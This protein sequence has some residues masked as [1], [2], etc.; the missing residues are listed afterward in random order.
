MSLH[1]ISP[2]LTARRV[3]A[4]SV[5]RNPH[6]GPVG[7]MR[8]GL[9]IKGADGDH[10]C[11]AWEMTTDKDVVERVT[12]LLR[13]DVYDA[14]HVL[15]SFR[16][17]CEGCEGCDHIGKS[18]SRTVRDLRDEA[19]DWDDWLS[20]DDLDVDRVRDD[21]VVA[22]LSIDTLADI[23]TSVGIRYDLWRDYRRPGLALIPD[24]P[25]VIYDPEGT[26]LPIAT[27]DT[28]DMGR[29]ND[30]ISDYLDPIYLATGIDKTS[31]IGDL[32]SI[33]PL[34]ACILY[35]CEWQASWAYPDNRDWEIVREW[36]FRGE[37][38]AAA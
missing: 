3:S 16:E 11:V 14:F 37:E 5:T 6:H 38:E 23:Y 4:V 24:V 31:A 32:L 25:G 12:D 8:V 17:T 1:E 28:D 21:D 9:W 30:F 15:D 19:C 33:H 29:V 34:K 7:H 22:A 27:W 20:S 36:N 26:R 18:R 10:H 35:G 2:Y 13:H